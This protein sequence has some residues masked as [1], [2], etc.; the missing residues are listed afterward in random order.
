MNDT[1]P[2]L[3]HLRAIATLE[4]GCF[5]SKE[6][7]SPPPMPMENVMPRQIGQHG[8]GENTPTTGL[9]PGKGSMRQSSAAAPFG[10]SAG[11]R[12]G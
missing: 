1:I 11:G 5:N 7:K 12:P 2:K 3:P 4:M 6:E 9:V 8:S 10:G